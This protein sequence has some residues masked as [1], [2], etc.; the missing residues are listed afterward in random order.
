V[1]SELDFRVILMTKHY[2]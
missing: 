1:N 2:H